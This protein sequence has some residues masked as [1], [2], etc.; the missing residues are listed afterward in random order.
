MLNICHRHKKPIE[1]PSNLSLT[2]LYTVWYL[3]TKSY[4]IYLS[5]TTQIKRASDRKTTTQTYADYYH[6][7]IPNISIKKDSIMGSMKAINKIKISL[8]KSEDPI[9]S[10]DQTVY[11]YPIELLHYAPLNQSDFR[12]ISKLP[13]ILV[14]IVQL[15]HI[16]RL[17]KFF[18]E[19]IQ[20][21]PVIEF[22]YFIRLTMFIL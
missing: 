20:C 16:E 21:Y 3:P 9:L 12:L 5:N 8:N 17:R 10:S 1:H 22:H 11:Y 15:Y 18:E 13:T 14:R 2:E 4:F 19:N 6:E 7:L